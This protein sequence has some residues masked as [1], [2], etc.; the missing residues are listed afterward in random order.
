M[1]K[2]IDQIE[3]KIKQ[4]QGEADRNHAIAVDIGYK[5]EDFLKNVI[6]KIETTSHDLHVPN[7]PQI[8]GKFTHRLVEPYKP[9]VKPSD[10]R[11]PEEADL[12]FDVELVSVQCYASNNC[13]NFGFSNGQ[14]S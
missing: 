5:I 7:L 12:S 14:I 10:Q 13:F 4:L 8:L 9:I 1:K 2:P 3:A 6:L 11:W